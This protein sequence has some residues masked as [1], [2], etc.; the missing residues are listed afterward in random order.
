L[1][2]EFGGGCVKSS[3]LNR[4]ADG[5]TVNLFRPPAVTVIRFAPAFA[6]RGFFH[7]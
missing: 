5:R 7:A 6:R 3:T 4:R 2:F 1:V